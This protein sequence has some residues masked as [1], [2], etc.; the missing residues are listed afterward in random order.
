[1]VQIIHNSVRGRARFKVK[2]LYRSESLKKHIELKLSEND[3]IIRFH[4]NTLTGN[5]LVFF[6]SNND[7]FTIL[8]IIKSIVEEYVGEK[9]NKEKKQVQDEKDKKYTRN[10][11]KAYNRRKIRRIIIEAEEQKS[12]PWHLMEPAEVLNFF[13]INKRLGLSSE[14]AKSNL[15]TYGPNLLPESVPRSGLSIFFEQ[16]KSIPVL[17]LGVASIISV[18]TGGVA[19]AIAIM[20]VVTINAIIGYIT[21]VQTEKAINLL[22][23]LSSPSAIVLRD[24]IQRD[25]SVE[26]VTPGDILILRPGIYIAADA[27]LLEVNNLSIDES[28]LTGESM[29]VLKGIES[30]KP[31]SGI[32]SDIPLADRTNMVYRGTLVTGGQGM[33]IVVATGKYTEIGKIQILVGEVKPPKTPLEQQLDKIGTQ[34]VYISGIVCGLLFIVGIIRGYGFLEMIKTSI[35]LAVAAVPEGL[36]TVA[37]TLLAFGIKRMKRNNV[38]IRNLEVVETLGC[39]QTICLDKTGTIT[40]N[41]MSVSEVYTGMRTFRVEK[42]RF[43]TGENKLVNPYEYVDLLKLIEIGV[44]CN[45]SMVTK[46]Q[47]GYVVNGTSTENSLIHLAISAGVDIL[48]LREKHPLMRIQHR[49]EK[50]NYMVTI[51]DIKNG[52]NGG[53]LG[54]FIAIKGSPSEILYLCKFYLKD[55]EKIPLSEE[56]LLKIEE[57]NEHLASKTYRVLGVAYAIVDDTKESEIKPLESI[58][59][60]KFLIKKLDLIWI[61]LIG[62]ADPIRDGVKE[63]IS[64]FHKAGI[65]TIMITGDQTPTAYAIGKELNISKGEPLQILDSTNLMNIEPETLKA[66]CK[67][68]NVF[69]RVSPANKLQIVQALQST[70]KIV[71][72]TGDGINDAPALKAADIGVAM[73]LTGTDVAREVADVV[74]EDDRLETMLIAISQGRTIYDNIRKSIHFL[75]STNMSEIMVMFSSIALGLGQPLNSMQLLW[76]NLLS[77]IA[78]GLALSFE[79]PEPDVM[80]RPPRNPDDPILNS[81]DFRRMLFESAVLTTSTFGAYGYGILRYGLGQKASTL[82]FVSLTLSQLTHAISCRSSKNSI[83]DRNTSMSNKYLNI[84]VGGSIALQILTMIVPGLRGLLGIAPIGLLDAVVVGGT[85]ISSLIINEATK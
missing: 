15:K 6:N 47:N 38:L 82:A 37:T 30:L 18:F 19:D 28:A 80:S 40:L 20:G 45:E 49:S 64:S 24:G 17:L 63:L 26:E 70:G 5:V 13:G 71:A 51:H 41:R 14:R 58:L 54:K 35:S 76:I 32:S 46:S 59:D 79:A 57:E 81:S 67:G 27:R 11:Q 53:S 42:D 62:M 72:M 44:L 2:G 66:L 84:A 21:E 56:D 48:S 43:Y 1:M 12:L 34:L 8:L 16:F 10:N 9:N 61:G 73:G 29:P 39:V 85:A 83:F 78:P 65:D 7:S 60:T 33:A 25:V 52:N 31:L 50:K 77:D 3:D 68:V 74:L 23:S 55:G 69:S 36:P 22:K 4:V 75:L